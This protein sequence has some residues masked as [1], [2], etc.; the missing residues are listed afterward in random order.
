MIRG[1]FLPAAAF[2]WITTFGRHLVRLP[3]AG[4]E[5]RPEPVAEDSSEIEVSI[6]PIRSEANKAAMLS[7]IP[8]ALKYAFTG[9]AS[10]LQGTLIDEIRDVARSHENVLDRLGQFKDGIPIKIK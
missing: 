3:D 9:D 4:V 10:G 6:T 5:I 1:N 8:S 7:L 2:T